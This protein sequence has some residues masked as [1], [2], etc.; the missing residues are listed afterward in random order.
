LSYMRE[1]AAREE[2]NINTQIDELIRNITNEPKYKNCKTDKEREAYR[3]DRRDIC[4]NSRDERIKNMQKRIDNEYRYVDSFFKAVKTG[5]SINYQT[6]T[7]DSGVVRVP[8]VFL[9]FKINT[10]KSNPYAPSAITARIATTDSNR[11]IELVLSGEQGEKLQAIFFASRFAGNVLDQWDAL[12][13]K[14]NVNRRVRYIYTGNL[15]QAFDKAQGGKLISYTC[16]NGE[17]KKGILMPEHWIPS[18][19][20]NNSRNVPLKYCY[21]AIAGL[22]NNSILNTDADVSFLRQYDG[23]IRIITKSLSID[24]FG[25]LVKNTKII[26]YIRE[27]GGFQK[28]GSSWTGS[29]DTSDLKKVI[30]LIYSEKSCNALLSA[31]Q[32]ELVQP[33]IIRTE[34]KEKERFELPEIENQKTNIENDKARR[35][36]IAKAKLK[37]LN[38]LKL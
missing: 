1:R 5:Q 4:E 33:D 6:V 9:G 27:H 20:G 22:S 34:I 29:V 28:T 12:I 35:I 19:M 8:A 36:R 2:R 25:W 32:V 21:K 11:Y 37:L 30:D 14:S 3:R 17:T 15:L 31:S 10:L 23:Y 24:K 38:L 16:K 26:P 18:E 7:P 13:Q